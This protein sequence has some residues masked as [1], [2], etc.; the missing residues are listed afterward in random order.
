MDF[1][2]NAINFDNMLVVEANERAG[3][4]CVLWKNGWSIREVEFNKNLI[5]V[6]I[7][8]VVCEWLMVGFYGPPYFSK[9]KKA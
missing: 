5:A 4:L 3:G 2:K 9:K 1:V 8:N 6:T 7:S